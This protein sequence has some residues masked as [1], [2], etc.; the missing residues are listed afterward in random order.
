M[1]DEEPYAVLIVR[2]PSEYFLVDDELCHATGTHIAQE[3]ETHLEK[4]G[5]TIPDWVK[6][7]CEEDWGVYLESEKGDS[8]YQYAIG[9]FPDSDDGRTMAVHYERK[10]GFWR[11]LLRGCPPLEIHDPIHDAMRSF[12]AR[13]ELSEL[14]TQEQF[15]SGQ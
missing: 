12:G 10:V 2:L 5:H 1:T 14:L 15:D 4:H 8:R 11:K 9:F 6:G 13:Y 3:L 7:G